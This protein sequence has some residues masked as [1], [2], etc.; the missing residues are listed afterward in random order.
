M[1]DD[2]STNKVSVTPYLLTIGNTLTFGLKN[3]LARRGVRPRR[4]VA[5]RPRQCVHHP[6]NDAAVPKTESDK[7]GCAEGNF[8]HLPKLIET[9]ED[10]HP[11]HARTSH[12]RSCVI[13]D[14]DTLG[15]LPTGRRSLH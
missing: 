1:S 10:R 5:H 6:L 15:G 7:A 3:A 14:L 9:L 2:F 12:R 8:A 11:A 4:Q 13:V